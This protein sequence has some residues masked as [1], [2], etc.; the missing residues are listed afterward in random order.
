MG[1]LL[2]E[3]LWVY[4]EMGLILGVLIVQEVI[5]VLD[6][7]LPGFEGT[8]KEYEDFDVEADCTALNEALDR[9]VIDTDVVIEVLCNRSNQQ[10]QTI[11]EN[12]AGLFGEDVY[13]TCDRI[14][15]DDL[16]HV[17]KGLL[18]SPIAYDAK[19]INGALKGIGSSD[20]DVLIEILCARP[21]GYIEQLKEFYEEKYGE[22]MV[23]HIR[24]NT[25]SEFECF[26]TCLC[27]AQREEGVDAID[28]DQAMEDAQELF[29]A[30]EERWLFTDE[31][32]FTR[33][34]ARR[35]W[36]QI[37]LIATKYEEISSSTLMQA[38][39]DECDG[40]TR[41]GYQA[42]VR[43][44]CDPCWY[45]TRNI[46]KAMK[47]LGTDDDALVR[48]IVF[49]SEWGLENMKAMYEEKFESTMAGDIDDDCR[50]DYKDVLLA[51]V[52]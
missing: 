32:V 27:M 26:L 48:N 2:I 33:I 4:T 22:N 43:M 6:Q 38:I 30:G 44:A 7:L 37:R 15:R 18:L 19:C 13:D 34:M 25:R 29:D 46:Y 21:N 52:K 14:R 3:R 40:D 49:T 1:P 23:E 17:V 35:S 50:G 51:I 11:R 36:L 5:D 16:R 24:S 41:R 28:E 10:R 12:Y 45:F 31:S 8:I 42:I 20:D 39:D 9:A 47:G